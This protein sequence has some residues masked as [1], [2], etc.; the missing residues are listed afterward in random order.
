[1]PCSNGH[2]R[3]AKCS[4]PVPASCR[5]CDREAKVAKEKLER[6]AEQKR[7]QEA[8]QQRHLERMDALDAQIAAA[9]QAKEDVLRTESLANAVKQKEAD[10]AEMLAQSQASANVGPSIPSPVSASPTGGVIQSTLS[11][12]GLVQP[13]VQPQTQPQAREQNHQP[14]YNEQGVVQVD[15]TMDGR[16]SPIERTPS[17]PT[18]DGKPLESI[19][20]AI[21]PRAFP[22]LP[23]SP[24]SLEWE[25]QKQFNGTVNTSID[26][27]MGMTGLE[28]VKKQVLQVLAKIEATTRQNASL[29]KERFNVV[30]LGNP[31]T[32][33][34]HNLVE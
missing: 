2:P 3:S 30:L 8:E 34:H 14:G 12:L 10:L 7:R 31:G 29:A 16:D 23:S 4:N 25:R 22:Q 24:S 17:S 6:E 15:A 19:V 18:G 26:A 1:M 5:R 13:Q 11:F 32:G 33:K 27:I 20:P 21:P 9:R 28:D